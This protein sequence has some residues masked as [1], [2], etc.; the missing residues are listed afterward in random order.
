MRKTLALLL[1]LT[2]GGAQA[3]QP[4]AG[5]WWNPN[6]SGS[7]FTIELQ[8]NL[9]VFT[10]YLGEP[11]GLPV[12][13]TSAGFLNGNA[14]YEGELLRFTNS[15]CAGCSYSGPP[16]NQRVGTI[17][18]AFDANDP[19]RGTLT[20]NVPPLPIRSMPIERYYYYYKRTGPNGDGSAP[21]QASK[22]LGEWSLNLDFSEFPNFNDFRFSGDVLVFDQLDLEGGTWYFDGCRSETS[23]DA[24]CSTDALRFNGASGFYSTSR[25]R[26]SI[27]LDDNSVNGSGQRLCMYYEAPV[28][29]EYFSAGATG[30]NDGG[31]TIFPCS[32]NPLNY[33]LYP[34]RG[35]RSASRTFVETGRGP[36]KRAE[37]AT[38]DHTP[39]LREAAPLKSV[40]QRKSEQ[41]DASYVAFENEVQALVQRVNAKR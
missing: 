38:V 2:A 12:W 25:R 3:Y 27:I 32:A 18:L 6:E 31:F 36:S 14:L 5:L 8:D 21:I 23:L 26:Q 9:L 33:A 30:N 11:N 20:W 28:Q 17:R 37:A 10:G 29:A 24:E 15:Q 34:L 7:G 1:A 19:T 4:E 41:D 16:Q 35:F 40:A 39:A 22:M 13:Y